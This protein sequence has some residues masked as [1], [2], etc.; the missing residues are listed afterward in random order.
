MKSSFNFPPEIWIIIIEQLA[1]DF[2]IRNVDFLIKTL[3]LNMNI[4]NYHL[5]SLLYFRENEYDLIE[6]W[7]KTG[8]DDGLSTNFILNNLNKNTSL[9]RTRRSRD[10]TVI[11]DSEYKCI[12]KERE[13]MD[14]WCEYFDRSQE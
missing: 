4:D 7:K 1:R 14:K 10:I 3:N 2:F 8:I 12:L 11:G 6:F 13:L 9:H 5:K